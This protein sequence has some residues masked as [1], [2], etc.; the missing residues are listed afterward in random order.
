[1]VMAGWVLA[2]KGAQYRAIRVQNKVL[3]K[4]ALA[5]TLQIQRIGGKPLFSCVNSACRGIGRAG[6]C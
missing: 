3:V 6:L 4:R 5:R 2:A 1:M